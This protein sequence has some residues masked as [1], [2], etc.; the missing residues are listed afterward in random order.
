MILISLL[1]HSSVLTKPS[2][3]LICTYHVPVIILLSYTQT[4]RRQLEKVSLRR[5]LD[6]QLR[7]LLP[8]EDIR[9]YEEEIRQKMGQAYRR[10]MSLE[11]QLMNEV[12]V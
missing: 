8:S 11:H 4:T 2:D 6:E 1:F 7:G 5:R 12:H 9:C 10:R 3:C